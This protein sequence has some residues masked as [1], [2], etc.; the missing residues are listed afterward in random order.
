M[1]AGNQALPTKPRVV[2]SGTPS[3]VLLWNA[4][5]FVVFVVKP[6]TGEAMPLLTRSNV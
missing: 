3:P 4:L 2:L 1:P 5:K 6:G